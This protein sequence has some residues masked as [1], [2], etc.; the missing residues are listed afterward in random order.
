MPIIL[1]QTMKLYYITIILFILFWPAAPGRTLITPYISFQYS[2]DGTIALFNTHTHEL[3][4][5]QYKD[6]E[7]NYIRH[8][9][10]ELNRLLRCRLTGDATEMSLKL[11][12]LIDNIEDHFGGRQVEVISGYRSPTLNS[13][14]RSGGHRV[15]GKSLHMA[16]LAMDIKMQGVPLEKI[17]DYARSLK[18]GGVGYYSGQFVHIDVGPVRYW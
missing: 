16:G 6:G 2:G 12:E 4:I 7:N 9:L 14:L 13:M 17:R 11:I 10:E 3:E 18:V 8:G 1:M 15:A 5:I